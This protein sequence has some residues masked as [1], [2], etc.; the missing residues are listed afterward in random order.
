MISQINLSKIKVF[1]LPLCVLV[2]NSLPSPIQQ[3]QL[4]ATP[5][6]PPPP[7]G[8]RKGWK[9]WGCY[10]D[11]GCWHTCLTIVSNNNTGQPVCHS[12][13]QGIT[14]LL[15]TSHSFVQ[16]SPEAREDISFRTDR[17]VLWESSK[18]LEAWINNEQIVCVAWVQPTFSYYNF[19]A[20][21]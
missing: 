11:K 12:T 19:N 4:Q 17:I 8:K 18:L 9:D 1:V 7:Q 5:L 15:R 20:L 21:F 13:T 6:P 3:G 2:E 16:R 14:S 10:G